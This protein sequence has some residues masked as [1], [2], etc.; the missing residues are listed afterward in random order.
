MINTQKARD[1]YPLSCT[2]IGLRFGKDADLFARIL[3][4]TS[5]ISTMESNLTKA[6]QIYRCV[7]L[8]GHVP[9]TLMIGSQYHSVV[10]LIR[11]DFLECGR[12]VFSFYRNLIGDWEPVAVDRWMMRHFGMSDSS[13]H[14]SPKQYDEIEGKI[15]KEARKLGIEPACRQ[16]EIWCGMWGTDLNYA[17]LMKR[18]EICRENLLRRLL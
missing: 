11:G 6:C 18:K 16:S 17:D 12:K 10:K 8:D 3:A 15:Q 14:L 9:T 5:P 13:A 2:E 7:K 4:G 1:W